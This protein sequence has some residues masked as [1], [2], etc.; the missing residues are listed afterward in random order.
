M[1]T[2]TIPAWNALGLLPPVDTDSPVSFH[3]S[4]YAVSLKDVAMRFATSAERRAVLR[5]FLGYRQAL[6]GLG[7]QSGFQWLDG[8]FME[9]VET[10]EKR[11]PRDMD[12][13]TFLN[14]PEGFAPTGDLSALEHANAKARFKVDA[15]WVEMNRL[16]PEQVVKHSAY[17]YSLWS[18]R[19][20][21]SWKGFLQIDLDP[22]EDSEALAWLGQCD[23]SG[24]QS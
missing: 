4:P 15:Y 22:A 19:R 7:L 10:L 5:G 18:H 11:P 6:H 3:R 9:D 1:T 12:V 17:W 21:Q 2:V 14:V 24:E 8:S 13:V 23:A 20:N 16:P